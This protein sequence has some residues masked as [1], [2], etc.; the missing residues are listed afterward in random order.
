MAV[1]LLTYLSDQFTP[2]VLDQLGQRIGESPANTGVAVQAIIPTVLGGLAQRTH[3]VSDANEIVDFLRHSKYTNTATPLDIA[4]VS[5]TAADTQDAVSAGGT[6]IERLFST[7]VEKVATAIAR[8]SQINRTSALSLMDLVGAVLEGILGRQSLENGLTGVNL[9]TLVGG[10]VAGI[11]AG[12]PAGL[13]GLATSLGFDKLGGPATGDE[14]AVTT[15]MSTPTNPDIPKSPLVERERENVGWLRWAMIA[16]GLLILFLI[17]QKC[18]Q[19]Q[20]G[21][22]G[23]YTDTTARSEPDSREDTSATARANAAES[24]GSPAGSI[25][26]GPAGAAAAAAEEKRQLD[27]PGGR[28]IRVADN[29]FNANLAQFLSGKTRPLPRTFTFENLTFETNS[30]RITSES[31]PNVNDLIEIMNAYPSLQI[32]I[33]G[34]TD[35]T[36]D[37]GANKKLSLE[38]ANA[39]RSALTSAGVSANRVTTQGFGA[40]KPVATNDSEEGRQQNRRIDVVVTKV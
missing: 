7:N 40:E 27:L 37:A 4:Q 1:N 5:N 3:S 39:I 6:F 26:G 17:V 36:G 14:Q 15:F 30:T 34:H 38:R 11:R 9:S 25:P 18:R 33:Q 28:R 19:P 32:N 2:A 22:D 12:L 8:H 10:Q 21:A 23:V 24:N 35:N 13:A 16:V 29:T 31:R 20:T